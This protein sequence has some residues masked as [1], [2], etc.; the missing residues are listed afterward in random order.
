[1]QGETM[2]WDDPVDYKAAETEIADY[3][4]LILAAETLADVIFASGRKP[5]PEKIVSI[6]KA[7]CQGDD[8]LLLAVF[9]MLRS[10]LPG[11]KLD[12]A[13]ATG[14]ISSQSQAGESL[15]P[16]LAQGERE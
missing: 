1:M 14:A 4:L 11:L 6:S 12:G 3:E 16:G 15:A 8:R 9:Q 5:T 2:S 13:P 7:L 10:V